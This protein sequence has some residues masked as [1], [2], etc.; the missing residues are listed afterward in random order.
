MTDVGL[1]PSQA[2]RDQF[3]PILDALSRHRATLAALPDV[4]TVR[5]GY[6]LGVEPPRPVIVLGVRPSAG[7]ADEIAAR[8]DAPQAGVPQIG[9]PLRAID[10]TPEEQLRAAP[11][12]IS[13]FERLLRAPEAAAFAPPRRGSYRPP[14]GPEAPRL[15]AVHGPMK[16]TVC[17]SPDAGWPILSEFLARPAEDRITVG[18][19]QFTAP[20]VY[21]ALRANLEASDG[22]TC[23]IGL[24]PRPEA[25]PESGTKAAD[26]H[27]K[28]LLERLEKRLGDRFEHTLESVGRAGAF[29]SAYHI[30]VAVVDDRRM[31][32]SSGNWQSSNLPPYD[33]IE[34][35]GPLPSGFAYR[36]NREYHVV[37]EHEGL[38]ATFA[39]FLDHDRGLGKTF[40][41]MV[42]EVWPD[43]FVS[44]EPEPVVFAPRVYR[45]PIQVERDVRVQPILTPD[46]YVDHVLPLIEGATERLYL[47]NQYINL[48]PSGNFPEFERLVLAL[49]TKIEA[50]VDVR[51]LLRNYMQWEKLEMLLAL[52]FPR[53]V[54][55]F[56]GGCHAK[57]IV[58]D[59]AR[60]LVGSHNWSNDGTVSNRDASLLFDDAEIATYF[61]GFFEEDWRVRG[62]A[63]PM[64]RQPRIA[65]DGEASF[66]GSARVPWSAW[67]DEPPRVESAADRRPPPGAPAV[68]ETSAESAP[69]AAPAGPGRVSFGPGAGVR[70]SADTLTAAAATPGE[71]HFSGVHGKTGQPLH[72]PVT[73]VELAG[74]IRAGAVG[75]LAVES[76][77]ARRRE[78]VSFGAPFGT[79]PNRLGQVGWG[80][81]YAEDTPQEVRDALAPLVQARQVAAG[82][83]F[84][85][86]TFHRGEDVLAFLG[87]HGV[88]PGSVRPQRVPY[89]LLLVGSPEAIPFET[90]YLLDL[91]YS[92]GRL[93]FDDVAAYGHYARGL[94]AYERGDTP[95]RPRSLALFGPRH[96][97]DGATQL[98]SRDLVI[99]LGD[100]DEDDLPS[101][102]ARLN[103]PQSV[104][105]AED[106]TRAR[107]LDLLGGGAG[108]PAL[109]L[110][111]GHGMGFDLGDPDQVRA[112]GALL[113]QDWTGWGGIRREHYVAA[114]DIT[115][116]MDATG[117][118]AFFFACY[119]A[120]TPA[121]DSFP[122]DGQPQPIAPAPFVAA[123][124][125]RLLGHAAHP[126]LA[127][128][129]HIERAW[130]FSIV[131]SNVTRP[132]LGTFEGFLG[133]VLTGE[134]V[135]N[136][137]VEFSGRAATLSSRLAD[138]YQPGARRPSD[139]ELV[140]SWIERNDTR[141][142]VLLGDPAA[143][144]R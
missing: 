138:L 54:F 82:R 127:V 112:Q 12:A 124:P 63:K 91:E 75:A 27:G 133:R 97:G 118:I 100:G 70:A 142:F 141:A 50:G 139:E 109:L 40:A 68:P 35:D 5:P 80:V 117:L 34:P 98:S 64:G 31:W 129:G 16:V 123:L 1:R 49:R 14:E 116:E 72:P 9:V 86:L 3:A 23:A 37:V 29:S 20:H 143:R 19:Y 119:G 61:E 105:V 95:A 69:P 122:R 121:R 92:V 71:V 38:A 83:Y 25:I 36:Y 67:S 87:R 73:V 81:V 120:G 57:L 93:H 77:V 132:Q 84:K 90:Q 39:G 44:E 13:E 42:E 21:E 47:Q 56:M 17:A 94:V 131:P 15:D 48:N 99:R 8:F 78:R 24:H 65:R 140:W 126:A 4:V 110:T 134:C 74:R 76:D 111:A 30:K 7:A 107:L 128:V 43:L 22:A 89:H 130:G 125:Q 62:G 137:T 28:D 46:N 2:V 45:P 88:A 10:A 135:G 103:L 102:A 113:T 6:D 59:G 11:T 96:S 53:R 26:I 114:A 79:D 58:A 108:Q 136:A 144:L 101:V 32:L 115:D 104:S 41:P 18:I 52:G 106:A 85:E 60:V 33:P 66:A 51:I 55:R